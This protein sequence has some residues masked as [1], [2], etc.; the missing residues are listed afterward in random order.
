MGGIF[1]NFEKN[2]IS[3]KFA[4]N[5]TILG[6]NVVPFGL[7]ICWDVFKTFV[8]LWNHPAGTIFAP[9]TTFLDFLDMAISQK[10]EFWSKTQFLVT[11]LERD[12]IK[13]VRMDRT[14]HFGLQ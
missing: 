4:I 13:V 5:I 6:C 11:N 7:G 2:F 14:D 8:L 9:E 3:I 10:S 12:L 1:W